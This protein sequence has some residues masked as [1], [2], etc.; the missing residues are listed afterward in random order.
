M[1]VWEK[2]QKYVN[3][4]KVHWKLLDPLLLPFL[5]SENQFV[6]QKRFAITSQ[7]LRA[8]EENNLNIMQTINMEYSVVSIYE[9]RCWGHPEITFSKVLVAFL[10]VEKFSLWSN[11]IFEKNE[12]F[13]NRITSLQFSLQSSI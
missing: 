2:E 8:F 5:W 9:L 4:S 10:K 11:Y 12:L 3:R 1:I 6:K 13:C 7:L